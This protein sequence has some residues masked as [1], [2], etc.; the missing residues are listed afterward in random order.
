MT[1]ARINASNKTQ[2]DAT[3][4]VS[5]TTVYKR[6]GDRVVLDGVSLRVRPG[7]TVA[8]VGPS[9]GGKSTLLRC[10]NGLCSFDA[11][12]VQVGPHSVSAQSRS[13]PVPPCGKRGACSA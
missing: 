3:D 5:L 11:G 13:A 10:L 8:I 1:W 6:Y 7:E 2:Q 9:G 4:F 12:S